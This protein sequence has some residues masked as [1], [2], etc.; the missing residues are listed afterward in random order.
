MG[1]G[2]ISKQLM[3]S[4][5]GGTICTGAPGVTLEEPTCSIEER[6]G[7]EDPYSFQANSGLV[8]PFGHNRSLPSPLEFT[9]HLLS[10]YPTLCSLSTEKASL[11][12]QQN[13]IQSFMITVTDISLFSAT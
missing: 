2:H 8:P 5:A 4:I 6:K 9:I 10:R 12:N 13:K 1:P 11:N 3:K 7:T